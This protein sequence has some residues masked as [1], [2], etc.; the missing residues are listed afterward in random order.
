[1]TKTETKR[2]YGQM[3]KVCLKAL[4]ELAKKYGLKVI[5]AYKDDDTSFR[6]GAALGLGMGILARHVV[7]G[8][9]GYISCAPHGDTFHTAFSPGWGSQQDWDTF[10]AD[11]CLSYVHFPTFPSGDNFMPTTIS[12]VKS[13][14]KLVGIKPKGEV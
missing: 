7:M 14:F 10:L 9:E 6:I 11:P 5:C 12:Q 1:M 3:R 4:R 2:R 8:D 13:V